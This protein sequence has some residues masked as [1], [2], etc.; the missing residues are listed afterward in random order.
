MELKSRT[1]IYAVIKYETTNLRNFHPLKK[2]ILSEIAT[3]IPN[4]YRCDYK[5][6]LFIS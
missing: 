6:V 4:M 5:P 1:L 3:Q 2:Y